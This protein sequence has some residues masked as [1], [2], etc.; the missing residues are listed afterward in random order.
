MRLLEQVLH[1][2]RVV[3][4][5]RPSMVYI[6]GG[7]YVLT[8]GVALPVRRFTRFRVF[9][10]ADRVGFIAVCYRRSIGKYGMG[11]W[12]RGVPGKPATRGVWVCRTADHLTAIATSLD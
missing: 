10:A 1:E 11:E 8:L 3:R 9:R 7:C 2:A 6:H 4:D 12:I 5:A